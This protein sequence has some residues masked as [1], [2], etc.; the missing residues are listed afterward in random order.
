[1]I[2]GNNTMLTGE[3]QLMKRPM[4]VYE[5]LAKEKELTFSQDERSVMVKGPLKAGEYKVAGNVSSQF[6]SGLIFA[7]PF[8]PGDSVIELLPPVESR[9]Y[10]DITVDSVRAFGISIGFDGNIIRI[11]GNQSYTPRSLTVEGDYS[12][13]AFLDAFNL[14]GGDVKVLGLNEKTHQGDYVYKAYFKEIENGCQ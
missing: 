8:T 4:S 6:I 14:L 7:L 5:T 10:I 9:A 11:K 13:A 2:S 1:M 3:P 12:N